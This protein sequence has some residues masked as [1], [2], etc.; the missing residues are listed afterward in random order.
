MDIRVVLAVILWICRTD[1]SLVIDLLTEVSVCV[2]FL[3]LDGKGVIVQDLF[4]FFVCEE[5]S[6]FVI[7]ADKIF[8]GKALGRVGFSFRDLAVVCGRLV[9]VLVIAPDK[10]P[11]RKQEF[12][13]AIG[14]KLQVIRDRDLAVFITAPFVCFETGIDILRIWQKLAVV[15]RLLRVSQKRISH[16]ADTEL[17]AFQRDFL[18]GFCIR[19]DDLDHI[20]DFFV[21]DII[22]IAIIVGILWGIASAMLIDDNLEF[23]QYERSIIRAYFPHHISAVRNIIEKQFA[24]FADEKR[25]ASVID[26]AGV[27]HCAVDSRSVFQ[28]FF[29]HESK[30]W[31]V[32][33]AAGF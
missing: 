30:I 21:S 2:R 4:C 28:W 20:L 23:L 13:Q 12:F 15:L 3:L 25:L 33:I 32:F 26:A 16:V 19:L 9:S 14:A 22:V 10:V 17:R 1:V 7:N 24:I 27:T 29:F 6:V 11:C 31:M 5:I 18:S 8:V